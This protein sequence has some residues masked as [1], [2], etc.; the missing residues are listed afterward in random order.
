LGRRPKPHW[1]EAR[2]LP[3]PIPLIFF[4]NYYENFAGLSDKNI[5]SIASGL[6]VDQNGL[7]S[8]K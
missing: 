7:L 8:Y 5:R 3:K 1:E 2:P 4:I 6:I